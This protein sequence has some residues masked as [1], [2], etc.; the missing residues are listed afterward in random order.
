MSVRYS[1]FLSIETVSWLVWRRRLQA[2]KS[3]GLQRR[4]PQRWAAAAKSAWRTGRRSSTVTVTTACVGAAGQGCPPQACGRVRS[5]ERRGTLSGQRHASASTPGAPTPAASSS[6]G[7][8]T[9]SASARPAS[10]STASAST[11]DPVLFKFDACLQT[12]VQKRKSVNTAET[13]NW[14]TAVAHGGRVEVDGKC[15]TLTPG[16]RKAQRLNVSDGFILSH[17]RIYESLRAAMRAYGSKWAR[18][19]GGVRIGGKTDLIAFLLTV[20]RAAE[21]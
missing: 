2:S 1:L 12:L 14:L 16:I 5:A 20:Q 18:K 21:C 6:T 10:S 11:H 17:P 3:A 15:V 7:G 13:L 8:A 4:L 19:D 9:A